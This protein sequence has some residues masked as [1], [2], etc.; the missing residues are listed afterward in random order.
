MIKAVS[1]LV[2]INGSAPMIISELALTVKAIRESLAKEYGEP[3]TEQLINR[4]MEVSKAEEDLD[5]SMKGLIQDVC[6]ILAKAD[7]NKDSTEDLASIFEDA[8]LKAL[9][10]MIMH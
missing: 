2:S 10:D 7:S 5:E 4:A 3:A 6:T 1:G 8:F 9:K